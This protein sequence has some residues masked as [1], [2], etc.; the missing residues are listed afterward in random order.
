M[1]QAAS[2][3]SAVE[4]DLRSICVVGLGYVGLPL[5]VAFDEAGHETVGYDIDPETVESLNRC[6]D[7]TGEVSYETLARSEASFATDPA[8]IRESDYVVVT[9][10]T[11]V[12]ETQSPDLRFVEEAG[13]TIGS[14]LSSGTTVVLESTVYPGATR[15]VLVPAIEEASGYSEGDE[16]HVAYSP[17]RVA[18]GDEEH[19][20]EDVVKIVG[21]EDDEVR[22]NVA[23]LYET[24]VD[25]GVH[26]V[27]S[28]EAAEAAKCVENIQRDLNIALV[29]ELAIVFDRMELDTGEVLE[30]AR[31]K[32]NFHDYSPGLVGGH[33]I[34]VDPFY[35]A[36]GSEMEG[37]TPKLT[38]KAREVNEYMPKHVADITLKA[39]NNCGNVINQSRI[40]FLGLTYK[41]NVADVRTSEVAGVISELEEYGV[42][43]VGYDP[44]ADPDTIRETFGIDAQ[45]SLSFED[46]DGIVVPT[47]HDVFGDVDLTDASERLRGE[48]FLVDVKAFFDESTAVEAGFH[49][50]RL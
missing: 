9:V 6:V 42:E 24:V 16:F 17:E 28:M 29:N 5:A 25:G 40:L 49:Y 22:E 32:W 14:Q 33:C 48:P 8:V 12:D 1:Q 43:V 19:G 20:L 15:D 27:Q 30:A 47:P 13:R 21:C 50:R 11:P 41:P 34:P 39:L 35:F 26:R 45:A 3:Q 23:E 2:E 38:L 18:P 36:Y 46:V 31:T 10:P 44:Y 4:S 37:Y 7:T